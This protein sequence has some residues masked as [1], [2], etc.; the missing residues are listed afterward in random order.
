M[1]SAIE[2]IY[3]M[4]IS[5]EIRFSQDFIQETFLKY[6]AIIKNLLKIYVHTQNQ[7][8]LESKGC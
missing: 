2:L 7:T 4:G 5:V 8:N 1:Q 6:S 3:I